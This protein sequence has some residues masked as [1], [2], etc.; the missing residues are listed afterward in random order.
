MYKYFREHR[1]KVLLIPLI[2]Y[3]IFLFIG[4]SL[5]SDHLSSVL[6]LS[7]K[8]KHFIAYFVLAFLL[9]L[10]FF[11]Q[12]KWEGIAK[13]YL[14]YT[15]MICTIYGGLDEL[16]Q[17]LVPNRSAEFYDWLADILGSSLGVLLSYFF[18]KIIKKNKHNLET[19]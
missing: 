4:T 3:W 18:L 16:H 5:P 19:N 6:D 15:L 10:N 9:S 7:D 14:L 13:Y 11:F 2:V 17:N 8:L 12:E 1:I